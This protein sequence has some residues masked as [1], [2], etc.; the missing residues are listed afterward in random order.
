MTGLQEMFGS[1]SG[2]DAVVQP[3]CPYTVA[4]S[5]EED[6]RNRPGQIVERL[7]APAEAALDKEAVDTVTLDDGAEVVPALGKLGSVHQDDGIAAL[8]SFSLGAV[9]HLGVDW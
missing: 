7:L 5:T 3:D 1:H 4:R 9:D 2:C 8:R 6:R